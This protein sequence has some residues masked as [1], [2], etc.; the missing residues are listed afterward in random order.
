MGR[1]YRPSKMVRRVQ[2]WKERTQ[3]WKE[4]SQKRLEE[5]KEK[6]AYMLGEK[7]NEAKS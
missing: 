4:K 6:K 3:K 1:R 7:K 5:R 2:R